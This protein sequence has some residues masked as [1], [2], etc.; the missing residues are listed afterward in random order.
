MNDQSQ[1][2]RARA[3]AAETGST[4]TAARET[5]KQQDRATIAAERI[6]RGVHLYQFLP[7]SPTHRGPAACG[8]KKTSGEFA[9][10]AEAVARCLVLVRGDGINRQVVCE[11]TVGL[12]Q[13]VTVN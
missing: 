9:T 12:V 11:E 4:V 6:G 7:L 1:G 10:D 3:L 5:I 2:V 8:G 13:I